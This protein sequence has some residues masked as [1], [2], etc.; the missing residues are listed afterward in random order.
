MLKQFVCVVNGGFLSVI[1]LQPSISL[2]RH[3]VSSFRLVY[4]FF[5]L[6]VCFIWFDAAMNS[7]DIRFV[8][9]STSRPSDVFF[10]F[11]FLYIKR[12]IFSWS[13]FKIWLFWIYSLKQFSWLIRFDL[14][15]NDFQHHW[16]DTEFSSS[17]NFKLFF[18][19][20]H[21]HKKAAFCYGKWVDR[22]FVLFIANVWL[23]VWMSTMQLFKINWK[24]TRHSKHTAINGH[25][26]EYRWF[27]CK[28]SCTKAVPQKRPLFNLMRFAY[29]AFRGIAANI[30]KLLDNFQWRI[31]F[32]TALNMHCWWNTRATN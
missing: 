3:L 14:G 21:T 4:S 6:L 20:T 12:L 11:F 24:S 16:S 5:I 2:F 19:H 18:V 23:P 17:L 15:Q 7:S 9:A 8:W 30:E 22:F 31:W 10:F 1:I 32:G 28:K 29:S 13:H 27:K 26:I 25:R